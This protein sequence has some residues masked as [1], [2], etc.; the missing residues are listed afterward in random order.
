MAERALTTWKCA[1]PGGGPT[2]CRS[3]MRCARD[4][5]GVERERQR[6]ERV[7][8]VD[9]TVETGLSIPPGRLPD[10]VPPDIDVG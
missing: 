10:G 4:F 7:E 8:G 6:C 1:P 9:D 2:G 3:H 5:S